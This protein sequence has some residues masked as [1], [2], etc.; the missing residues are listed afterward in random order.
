MKTIR[1]VAAAL[2]A[3]AMTAGFAVVG[4]ALRR[5]RSL[6]APTV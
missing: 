1:G 2:A 4:A 6:P 3:T 5:P